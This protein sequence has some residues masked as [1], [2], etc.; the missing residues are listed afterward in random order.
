MPWP[1][2]LPMDVRRE[3]VDDLLSDAF[4]MTE[5]CATYRIS[6]KTGYKWL[7]RFEIGGA[8]GLRDRSRRPHASPAQVTA[9]VAAALIA[10]RHR[11]PYW[12]ARKLR[13][14]LVE[15]HPSV[16]W[17]GCSTIHRL[18]EGQDLVRRRSRLRR[19]PG[20]RTGPFTI[21][22][23][24]N[25]VWT[26]DF[27]GS[28]LLRSGA[29]CYPLT[30]RDL[31]SRYV[32]RC[33]ALRAEETAA[34][35]RCLARAFATFG[36]PTS[37]RSDN[38]KPFASVGLAQLSRLAV[39]W[40][41][42]GI[43][44]ERIAP[45]H[46]EQNGAHER[47]HRDLKAQTTRPPAAAWAGQ[48]R[49]FDV[50]RREYNDERPHEA[51]HDEVPARRYHAS[52]R[53]LPARLPPVEYPGHWESRRVATNGCVSWGTPVFLSEALA[54]ETVAFEE[55]DDGVWTLHFATLALA[56]WL[57]RDR[58]FRALPTD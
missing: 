12:G 5:L 25:D 56:R 20:L 35:Q 52:T 58:C 17:P 33:D 11:K 43:R 50:F 19:L 55:V 13:R 14:W 47:F 16:A 24:P 37:I 4:T 10:A 29:R 8:L 40:L 39:W 26:V 32:L 27:K 57:E 38:G 28:F 23:R 44:V 30:L 15:R 9:A 42:L 54:G 41:R 18:L 31:A 49:R 1:E 48:Q 53:A 36:L 7:A 46:P 2:M 45:G 6:R 22:T 51:L 3:F 21:A 34:T